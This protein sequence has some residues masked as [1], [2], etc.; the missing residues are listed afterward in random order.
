[1]WTTIIKRLVQLIPTLIGVSLLTF[2]MMR[3]TPG[4]PV[5]QMLGPMAT[6]EAITA[7]RVEL[8][9]QKYTGGNP[10]SARIVER[11]EARFLL[12]LRPD[13][14][15]PDQFSTGLEL[16]VHIGEKPNP[17]KGTVIDPALYGLDLAPGEAAMEIE[18][19]PEYLADIDEARIVVN[20]TLE[21]L[22]VV[23][24]YLTW[25]GNILLH[26]DLGDSI[27][28]QRPVTEEIF[29]RIGATIE[30]AV[31]AM[32]FATMTGLIVGTFS[33]VYPR[34]WIDNSS[35]LFVFIFL[36]MPSF[37]LGLELIIIFSRKLEWFPPAGRGTLGHLFLPA[38]TLGISTGAF[39]SRILRSSMLQVLNMDYIR[40]AQ[41]KGLAGSRV[42]LK[43][44]LKNA[45]IPF[46]TVAGLSLG[47]LL[48]GSVIVETIFNWPGI[49]K[50]VIDSIKSRD[51]PVT[52]GCVL[53]L[54]TIFVL[55]NLVVDMLYVVL[56]PRIRLEGDTD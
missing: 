51:Y 35:R 34:T 46:V 23:T 27:T 30:L 11:E 24:Q 25:M 33:A 49:G 4:D 13:D 1:M 29:G 12:I 36:A 26:G 41:A 28:S 48:G 38:T 5:R 37:W 56:D 15:E 40:T 22:S 55:V 43:H 10:Y 42:V 39:L 8:G 50:L 47:A 31:V 21:D 18:G 6:P 14:A 54:A 7:K 16:Q 19:H 32:F 44:A 52:M 53:V 17:N 2:A 45:L 20:A 3:L 9:F